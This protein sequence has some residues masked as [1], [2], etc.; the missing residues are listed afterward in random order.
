MIKGEYIKDGIRVINI[1]A[2]L[3]VLYPGYYTNKL[4][5]KISYEE[6]RAK[7]AEWAAANDCSLYSDSREDF[8]VSRGVAVALREGRS[9][10]IVEDLS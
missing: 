2:L 6:A 4:F 5:L 7:V 1:G 10:V 9:G 8:F 3:E